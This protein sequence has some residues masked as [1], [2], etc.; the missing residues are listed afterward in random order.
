[1][2]GKFDTSRLFKKL[3]EFKNERNESLRLQKY[4]KELTK[5]EANNFIVPLFLMKIPILKT[6]GLYFPDTTFRYQGELW[7]SYWN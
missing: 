3:Y 6:K 4:S 1:H 7:K 5:F 2:M